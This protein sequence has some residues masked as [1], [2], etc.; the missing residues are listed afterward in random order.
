MDGTRSRLGYALRTLA[1]TH[2][3]L[4]DKA[5]AIEVQREAVTVSAA[6]FETDSDEQ[7]KARKAMHADIEATLKLY[8]SLPAGAALP[9]EATP[10]TSTP[11]PNP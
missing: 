8:E 1:R 11:T 4:G 3:E 5:K 9:K 6:A 2:W 7:A 10:D